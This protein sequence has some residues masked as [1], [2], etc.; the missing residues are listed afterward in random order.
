MASETPIT[1]TARVLIV[2]SEVTYL[3][4]LPNKK[5]IVGHLARALRD[6]DLNFEID[7]CVQVEMTPYD[8]SKGRI[9]GLAN[10]QR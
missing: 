6:T 1:T 10:L 2:L 5:E 3:I 8:F 9:V 4:A 7:D